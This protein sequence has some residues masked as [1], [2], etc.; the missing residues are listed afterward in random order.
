MPSGHERAVDKVLQ[1]KQVRR[2]EGAGNAGPC[3]ADVAAV[4]PLAAIGAAAKAIEADA[5]AHFAAEG[6]EDVDEAGL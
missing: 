6:C 4:P 3:C 1:V 2:S 5:L